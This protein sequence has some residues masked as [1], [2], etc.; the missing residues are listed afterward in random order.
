MDYECMGTGYRTARECAR[1]FVAEW[2]SAGGRNDASEIADG[3]RLGYVWLMQELIGSWGLP[4]SL[5]QEALPE[6]S[7]ALSQF[8]RDWSAEASSTW[9]QGESVAWVCAWPGRSL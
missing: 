1:A 6:V 3:V 8:L 2:M 5:G 9:S 7:R 4:R